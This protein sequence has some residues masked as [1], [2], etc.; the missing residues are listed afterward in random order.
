MLRTILVAAA[1]A[2]GATAVTAQGDP[3]A[4]RKQTMKGVG[5]ATKIGSAMAKGEAPFDA[6]KAKEI[7]RT[8]ASAAD[9]MH[10]YFPENSKTGGETTAAPK[11]WESQAEFRKRF[12]DW[13]D[14]IKK[15]SAQTDDLDSFKTAFGTLTKACGGCH[16]TFRIKKN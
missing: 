15:A 13:A 6:A 4:T 11:I 2:I 7:L 9:K 12:H 3:I 1:L 16:E 10:T 14:D 5:D 8:Y